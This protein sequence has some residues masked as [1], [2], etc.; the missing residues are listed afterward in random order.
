MNVV[1]LTL[2]APREGQA[3]Y[4]HV[5]EIISG[6][7]DAEVSVR[8]YKPKYTE[9]KVSPSLPMRVLYSLT[10]QFSLWLQWE[11]GSVL[12]I[13]AHY[14][15]FPTACIA[16]L[17]GI[18][19]IHEINGPYE[20]VFVTYPALNR[21]RFL[22]IPMQRWQYRCASGLI[23]V[24][25]ELVK[26]SN[27]QGKR[28]DCAFISNGA[29]TNMFVP[30]LP[31]PKD[32]PDDYVLFFGGL[33]RWHGVPVMMDATQ[34]PCWPEHVKLLVIGEGQESS[35]VEEVAANDDKVIV[36]GRLPY[37]EIP[38]Y[39]SNALPGVIMISDP[40]NRSATGVFPLKLFETLSGGIP[41]IVSDLPGQADF[42]NEYDCGIVVP[43]D[44][45]A[46]LAKAVAFCS[47]N[48]PQRESMGSN[49]R[50]VVLAEHS[51]LKRSEDTLAY[52]H[53]VLGRLL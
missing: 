3:S 46:A 43:M 9:N 20:D 35:F 19:V 45:S 33:T 25:E 37:N 41:A 23:A 30:D 50:K 11:K 21:F 17:F 24:T 6:L 29:N 8:L 7:R 51:W 32:L 26:W 48:P 16:K 47:S 22:L 44:D 31:C 40:D 28:E 39:V 27:E 38:P 10:L 36:K 5:H 12:Y 2:E 52:M 13:R 15:A 42:V 14:L 49:G 18:P 53:Y 34:D 1:Y 4:V